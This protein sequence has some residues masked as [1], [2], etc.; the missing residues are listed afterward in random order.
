MT[1]QEIKTTVNQLYE[2]SHKVMLETISLMADIRD[3][4][5]ELNKGKGQKVI[6]LPFP[7]WA[8]INKNKTSGAQGK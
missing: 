1:E 7:D 3:L 8:T 5:D 4:R 2:V 6:E